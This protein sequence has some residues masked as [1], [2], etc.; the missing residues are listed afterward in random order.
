[1]PHTMF[2]AGLHSVTFQTTDVIKSRGP[3][4]WNGHDDDGDRADSGL[5][6]A[7]GDGPKAPEARLTTPDLVAVF[8]WVVW[9]AL[10]LFGTA[11]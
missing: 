11:F 2:R 4:S 8:V 7:Y 5:V 1:M 6:V 9:S 10:R 3:V